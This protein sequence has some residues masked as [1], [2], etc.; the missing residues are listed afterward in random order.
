MNLLTLVK[1]WMRH[2]SQYTFPSTK[3]RSFSQDAMLRSDM[4]Q[5]V[6]T[7][8]IADFS[9]FF[10]F[11]LLFFL[12]SPAL[13]LCFSNVFFYSSEL[14]RLWR[15][16]NWFYNSIFMTFLGVSWSILIFRRLWN[17]SFWTMNLPFNLSKKRTVFFFS[18]VF[19]KYHISFLKHFF[20]V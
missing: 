17:V 1:N 18:I 5:R 10:F 7:S 13:A 20:S 14:W 4:K 12:L 3:N 19:F 15:M 16:K 6:E 8:M 9:I 11:Y 2:V